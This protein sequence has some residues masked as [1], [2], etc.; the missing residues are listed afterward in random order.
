MT[1]PSDTALHDRPPIPGLYTKRIILPP[2]IYAHAVLTKIWPPDTVLGRQAREG[3]DENPF[4]TS[5]YGT[6]ARR[7]RWGGGATLRDA[8]PCNSAPDKDSVQINFGRCGSVYHT[9]PRPP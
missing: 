3:S 9:R 1:I 5:S 4:T 2:S 6:V 7:E 8:V